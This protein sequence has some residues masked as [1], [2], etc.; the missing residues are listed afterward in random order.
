MV[1]ES[2]SWETSGLVA[3]LAEKYLRLFRVTVNKD[4]VVDFYWNWLDH[5]VKWTLS[6]RRA[7]K[8]EEINDLAN[9]WGRLENF[10]Y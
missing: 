6:F 9:L 4:A 10:A 5:R 3:C 1:E 2:C 7:L 8:D